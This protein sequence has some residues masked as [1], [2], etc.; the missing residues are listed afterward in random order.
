LFGKK[1]E[2]PSQAIYNLE[3]KLEV[4]EEGKKEAD[5]VVKELDTFFI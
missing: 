4:A 1:G 2:D 5:K 3:A